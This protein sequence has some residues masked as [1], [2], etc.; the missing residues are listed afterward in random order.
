MMGPSAT[1]GEI[2]GANIEDVAPTAMY[3]LGEPIPDD[4]EGRLLEEAIDPAR[5]DG[6]PPEYA[7]R[8]DVAQQ[9]AQDYRAEDLDEVEGRLRDLGYIE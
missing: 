8:A 2:V 5:L 9:A 1:Q 4:F 3:L 6:K 7:E